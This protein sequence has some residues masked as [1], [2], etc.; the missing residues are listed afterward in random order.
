MAK[1]FKNDEYMLIG[2]D[3]NFLYHISTGIFMNL[4]RE[5]FKLTKN[6]IEIINDEINEYIDKSCDIS[7]N[8]LKVTNTLA[9]LQF[10]SSECCNMK[11]KY[12]YANEGT[13]NSQLVNKFF[14]YNKYL[15]Y[16]NEISRKYSGGIKTISFF[17]GEPLLNFIEIKKFIDNLYEQQK[18]HEYS[19]VTNGTI[20][21]PE[22][23]EMLKK[24]KF[25]ITVS[26]DGPK[27]IND[28]N[29]IDSN[30]HGT[31]DIVSHFI[32]ELNF[33][34]IKPTIEMTIT[35]EHIKHYSKGCAE[36]WLKIFERFE[37]NGYAT[38]LVVDKSIKY[39]SKELKKI[40]NLF[41]EFV[42]IF[43]DDIIHGKSY[44]NLK[45]L[46][47][48]YG[49]INK[50]YQKDCGSGRSITIS[51]DG[52]IYPC[53]MFVNDTNYRMHIDSFKVNCGESS[54]FSDFNAYRTNV[55]TCKECTVRNFCGVWCKGLNFL[56]NDSI[57]IPI[58]S[59][60]YTEKILFNRIIEKLCLIKGEDLKDFK[61]N[62]R[63]AVQNK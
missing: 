58:D 47:M 59:R 13:Y 26:L 40:K 35:D 16:Y 14:D 55:D 31:F 15:K 21:N 62:I 45:I 22:I 30:N 37:I 1:K 42:D 63:I 54:L 48:V 8:Q 11:C 50:I 12:C 36:K 29:R 41:E 38:F 39:N 34:G 7:K 17:G 28:I 9:S 49:I 10:M 2:E 6:S 20:T 56:N 23:F 52:Y 32:D 18:Y 61:K 44:L 24:Q 46:K 43:F 53:Q 19:I 3:E 25:K 4:S 33:I 60:C 51:N 5:D 27:D 57:N